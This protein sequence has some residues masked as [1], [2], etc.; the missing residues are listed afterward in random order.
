[1]RDARI[2]AGRRNLPPPRVL[3]TGET[4]TPLRAFSSRPEHLFPKVGAPVL[5]SLQ[6]GC[7]SAVHSQT[8][9]HPSSTLLSM[10]NP[11]TM[12]WVV[13]VLVFVGLAIVIWYVGR[14]L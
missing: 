9:F 14:Q 2:G 13:V 10:T 8:V 6:P 12:F 4:S 7:K 5:P 11:N 3:A 1:M